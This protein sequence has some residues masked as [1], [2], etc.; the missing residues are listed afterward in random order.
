MLELG[1]VGGA[2]VEARVEQIAHADAHEHD[3]D[4]DHDHD[5]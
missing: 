2:E 5:H 3:H 4:H 1:L